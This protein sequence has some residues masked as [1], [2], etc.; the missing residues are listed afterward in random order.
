MFFLIDTITLVNFKTIFRCDKFKIIIQLNM[1][2]NLVFEIFKMML[3]NRAVVECLLYI[4]S[5][6]GIQKFTA[7]RP[8]VFY[9]FVIFSKEF[10]LILSKLIFNVLESKCKEAISIWKKSNVVSYFQL[11]VIEIMLNYTLLKITFNYEINYNCNYFFNTPVMVKKQHL[12]G[13]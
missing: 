7:F 5:D 6:I 8:K 12:Q 10:V 13:Q 4:V 1:N 2:N 3:Y 11:N 9:T